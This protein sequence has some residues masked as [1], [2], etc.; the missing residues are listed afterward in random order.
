[1]PALASRAEAAA[2]IIAACKIAQTDH[3]TFT[4]LGTKGE[5]YTV[6]SLAESCSCPDFQHR[7][8]LYSGAHWCKH[9]LAALMLRAFARPAG[10][11]RRRTLRLADFRPVE[12]PKPAR[13]PAA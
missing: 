3:H 4:V 9:H 13:R 7:A 1:V 2:G 5:T 10:V 6:N 11:G 8:P 12:R